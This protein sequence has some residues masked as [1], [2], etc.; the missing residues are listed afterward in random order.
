MNR[1]GVIHTT[2]ATVIDI[3]QRILDTISD[4]EV[5]NILDDSI[6]VDMI[7]EHDKNYV[8]ERWMTYAGI[9]EKLGVDAILSACSSVGEFADEANESMDIPVY[10]IDEAMAQKAIGKYHKISVL[11]TLRTT[12]KPTVN[13]LNKLAA[14]NNKQVEINT[15]LVEGAYTEL[16][17]GNKAEHDLKI[18]Q[19]VKACL[20]DSEVIVLAQASM[21][22]AIQDMED[23]DIEEKILTSPDLGILKLKRDLEK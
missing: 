1:I 4:I 18:K 14:R 17:A 8:K 10:R 7:A 9:L 16:M 19:A 13:L 21:A 5:V 20:S 11:A 15:V 3:K 6:L 23:V 2:P 22:N 12:L